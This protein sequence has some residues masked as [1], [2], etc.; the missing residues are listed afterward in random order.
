MLSVD[1]NQMIPAIK[2]NRIAPAHTFSTEVAMFLGMGAG[3]LAVALTCGPLELHVPDSRTMCGSPVVSHC[4]RRDKDN[5]V[6]GGKVI[7]ETLPSGSSELLLPS[8]PGH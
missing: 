4:H 5:S 2:R 1:L 3:R 6:R 8:H 7:R